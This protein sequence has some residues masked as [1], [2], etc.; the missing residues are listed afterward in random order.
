M[1]LKMGEDCFGLGIGQAVHI[2]EEL[3][4]S[5]AAC[6]RTAGYGC[7]RTNPTRPDPAEWWVSRNGSNVRSRDLFMTRNYLKYYF[8]PVCDYQ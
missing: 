4:H 5:E 8:E 1:K 2:R 7:A 3:R 6:A